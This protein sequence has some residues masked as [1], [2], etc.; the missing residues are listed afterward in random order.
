MKAFQTFKHTLKS[1]FDFVAP[2]QCSVCGAR[3]HT[4]Q[5]SLCT[6]CLIDLQ[7]SKYSDGK[8]GNEL[9][10]AL[11]LKFPVRRAAAFLTYDRENSQRELIL[12]LK[13]H[14]RPKIGQNIAPL[15]V[16]SL[17]KSDFFEGI[18]LIIPIPIPTKRRINRGY[19]QSEQ[20]AI[21]I[22][23]QTGIPIRT[24]AIKR[25]NYKT[26]QTHL[27]ATERQKNVQ[28]TFILD[29]TS[30]LEGKHLLIVDDVITTTATIQNCA[31]CLC[32]IPGVSISIL[33]LGVSKNLIRNIK[34][35]NPQ[36]E[37]GQNEDSLL[38]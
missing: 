29:K 14:N 15:F 9:E 26:S 24:N 5:G 12:D 23:K 19:N 20:L 30:N 27:S 4:G 8:P 33:S 1:L 28:D 6:N 34:R 38:Q 7:F 17:Q 2:R 10:R 22:N 37:N 16:N 21:G 31:K 13:Y 36:Q 35:S 25:K 18:D 32:Q 11:W 3:L